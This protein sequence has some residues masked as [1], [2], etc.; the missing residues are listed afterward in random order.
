MVCRRRDLSKSIYFAETIEESTI[1]TI[2]TLCKPLEIEDNIFVKLER[3]INAS[4]YLSP[5]QNNLMDMTDTFR[6]DVV[7]SDHRYFKEIECEPSEIP[8]KRRRKEALLDKL[9]GLKTL[10]YFD[11]L[12]IER[13]KPVKAPPGRLVKTRQPPKV[14]TSKARSVER[15]TTMR[16]QEPRQQRRTESENREVPKIAIVK[17]EVEKERARRTPDS[18]PIRKFRVL[19]DD[20]NEGLGIYK[21]TSHGS[22]LKL[23]MQRKRTYSD[24]SSMNSEQFDESGESDGLANESDG[25]VIESDG[26]SIESD[27]GSVSRDS[28]VAHVEMTS[29]SSRSRRIQRRRCPCCR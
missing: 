9:P 23:R 25:P 15:Q 12:L 3:V 28:P 16:L 19:D 11:L 17:T 1:T 10:R 27:S 22:G 6:S 2:P 29:Y 18:K 20:V 13:V 4:K 7:R 5:L 21:V 14:V 24:S 26:L 8:R